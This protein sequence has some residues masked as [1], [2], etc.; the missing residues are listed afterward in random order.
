MEVKQIHLL[1]EHGDEIVHG[2][3]SFQRRRREKATGGDEEKKESVSIVIMTIE[4]D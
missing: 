2:S 3:Y 4:D 1:T